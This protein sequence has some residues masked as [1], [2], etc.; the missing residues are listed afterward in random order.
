MVVLIMGVSGS[1]KSTVGRALA[2]NSFL[3]PNNLS[4]ANC[5]LWDGGDEVWINDSSTVTIDYSDVQGGWSG[6]GSNNINADP[7]F[8]QPPEPPADTGLVS[9]ETPFVNDSR[10]PTRP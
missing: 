6:P 9:S 2:F 1:G 4:M 7:L 5:I 8:V 3:G 10:S